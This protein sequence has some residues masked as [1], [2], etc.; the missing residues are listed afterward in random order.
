MKINTLVGLACLSCA[1]V[2]FFFI[3]K[4]HNDFFIFLSGFLT[5][6]GMVLLIFEEVKK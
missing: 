3:L 2:L 5:A 1:F 4:Q 6:L